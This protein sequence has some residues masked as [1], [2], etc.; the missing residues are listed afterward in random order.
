MVHVRGRT[1]GGN[2]GPEIDTGPAPGIRAVTS[3]GF[4]NPA[5]G[6]KRPEGGPLC[7]TEDNGPAGE[8]N[9]LFES[10]SLLL[11]SNDVVLLD[12]RKALA[13]RFPFIWRPK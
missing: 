2:E 10:S 6:G 5:F 8:R 1:V 4:F 12:G 3:N 13:N 7:E 9:R 11:K